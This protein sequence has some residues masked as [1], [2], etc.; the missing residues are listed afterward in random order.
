MVSRLEIDILALQH[1]LLFKGDD[2]GRFLD[3]F[4]KP[5]LGSG[6]ASFARAAT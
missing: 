2:V 1:A 6:V 5:E 3:W 4:K